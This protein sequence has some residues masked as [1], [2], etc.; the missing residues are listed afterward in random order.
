MKKMAGKKQ[1]SN[2]NSQ[3]KKAEDSC[4]IYTVE[5][6]INVQI[7]LTRQLIF[8]HDEVVT[9]TPSRNS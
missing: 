7:Y 6:P 9:K 4:H 5:I 3:S 8:E 1:N 2:G